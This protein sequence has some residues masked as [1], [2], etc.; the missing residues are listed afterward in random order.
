VWLEQLLDRARLSSLV[1]M[2]DS[3]NPADKTFAR[4]LLATLSENSSQGSFVLTH[5]TLAEI[6][7]L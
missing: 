6:E 1:Q 3:A 2:I 4:R 7:R 5:S